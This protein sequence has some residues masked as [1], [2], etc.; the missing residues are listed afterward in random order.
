MISRREFLYVPDDYQSEKAS[1]SY[2]MSLIGITMGIL[3]PVVHLFS[4]FFY[5]WGNRKGPFF[6]RWH[7]I[8]ALSLQVVIAMV[9]VTAFIWSL[10]ILFGPVEITNNYL[11]Y[12]LAMIVFNLASFIFTIYSAVQ[13]RKGRHVYWYLLGPVTDLLCNRNRT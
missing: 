6:V 11:G 5:F 9:N 2:L 10:Y 1:N 12:I 13:T 7:C 4:T 8:Q 3:L